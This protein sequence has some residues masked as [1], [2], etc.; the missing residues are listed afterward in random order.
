MKLYLAIF[1]GSAAAMDAWKALDPETRAQREQA[2]MQA[3]QQWATIHAGAIADR[4]APLG[5]TKR[6]SAE[7]IADIRNAMGAWTVVRAETHEQAAAMFRD[8]PHFSIFAG[9]G[10]EVMECLPMPG[11]A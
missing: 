5:R 9:D 10:V 8:H 11:P 4:G 1:T 2:G 6:V 3:W 7:G